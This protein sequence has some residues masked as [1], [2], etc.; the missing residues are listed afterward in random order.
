MGH[1]AQLLVDASAL[2]AGLAVS[3][4]LPGPVCDLRALMLT[5]Y[6]HNWIKG[7]FLN[8]K[9]EGA[10]SPG[11]VTSRFAVMSR[12]S[13]ALLGYVKWFVQWRQYCFFPVDAVFDKKC[14][15]EIAEFCE[16]QTVEHRGRK[17]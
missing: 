4:L 1:M 12:H 15:R 10:V 13:G 3:D 11:S 16:T 9:N 17:K 8:F 6:D 7:E 14:L 5:Q 2:P